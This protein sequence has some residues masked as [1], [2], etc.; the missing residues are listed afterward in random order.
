[1]AVFYGGLA[2]FYAA[3]GVGLIVATFGR[4]FAAGGEVLAPFA[5]AIGLF[6]IANILVG[7]HLSRGETRYAWV[8]AA[9]VLVQV[10][11]LILFPTSLRGV[12]WAN[13]AIG[14]VLI[15]AHEL[16]IGSSRPALRAGLR[17]AKGGVATLRAA[18]PEAG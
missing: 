11:V 2:L 14:G 4:D 5:L 10:A 6:S 7:Y 3:A 17:H 15:A 13:V 1:T 16:L 8:V 9:G 18:L 12:V